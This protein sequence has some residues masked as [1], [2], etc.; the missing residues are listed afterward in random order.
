MRA[1]TTASLVVAALSGACDRSAPCIPW[2][3]DVRP[4]AVGDTARFQTGR[5]VSSDCEGG[6]DAAFI[7]SSLDSTIAVVAPNGLVHGVA[8]GMFRVRALRGEDTLRSEGFVLPRGWR[9]RIEPESAAV[10]VGDSVSF[11]VVAYDSSGKSLPI[12]PFWLITEEFRLRMSPEFSSRGAAAELTQGGAY[13]NVTVPGYFRG[14]RAGRTTITGQ[15]GER[16][17]QATLIILPKAGA[18]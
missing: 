2:P 10:Y 8:P 15:I 9:P 12:V 5:I 17:V 1:L 14:E 7:W 4:L 3:A 13:Q 16:R 11:R 6:A 18:R